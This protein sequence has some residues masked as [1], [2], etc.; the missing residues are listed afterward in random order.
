MKK[1]HVLIVAGIAIA[2][3]FLFCGCPFQEVKNELINKNLGLTKTLHASGEQVNEGI[4]AASK[5]YGYSF[6][7]KGDYILGA[8]YSGRY[9]QVYLK[10]LDDQTTSLSVRTYVYGNTSTEKRFMNAVVEYLESKGL[11]PLGASAPAAKAAPAKDAKK[12]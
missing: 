11:N 1:P 10:S 7:R 3:S 2:V 8:T 4:Q 5:K 12:K 6:K 9:I